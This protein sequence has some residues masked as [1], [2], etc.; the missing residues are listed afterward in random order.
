MAL[1]RSEVNQGVSIPF[2]RDFLIGACRFA[3]MILQ[4]LKQMTKN[5]LSHLSSPQAFYGIVSASLQE[6]LQWISISD[7]TEFRI[8]SIF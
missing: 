6:V 8:L 1:L 3:V 4:I 2:T 7:L 5:E